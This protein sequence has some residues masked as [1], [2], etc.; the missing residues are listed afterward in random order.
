MAVAIKYFQPI[1]GEKVGFGR[2][3]IKQAIADAILR[4]EHTFYGPAMKRARDLTDS[5]VEALAGTE[6]EIVTRED[7]QNAVKQ[8]MW[9]IGAY[10]LAEEYLLYGAGVELVE[11]GLIRADQFT[12]DGVPREEVSKIYGWNEKHDCHT[13]KGLN[14]WFRGEGGRDV[15][16]LIRAAEEQ[17]R[18]ELEAAAQEFLGKQG[19]RML[20]VCGPSSSGKTTTANRVCGTISELTHGNLTFRPLEVD[21]FFQPKTA[22][23]KYTYTV[24]GK[25]V[26]D[27]DYETPFAYDLAALNEV[28]ERI[29]R[30]ETVWMPKYDFGTGTNIPNATE[31]PALG[32]NEVLVF[33]CLHALY[34]DITAAVP[35]EQKFKLY[36]EAMNTIHGG[37]RYLRWTDVR[38]IRRMLRDVATRGHDTLLTLVHWHLVRKGEGA[39][40]PLINTA[41]VRINGGLAYELPVFKAHAERFFRKYLEILKRNPQLGDALLRAERVCELFDKLETATEEQM[42]HIPSDSILREFIGGSKF[43]PRFPYGKLSEYGA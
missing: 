32:P 40:F 3:P 19:M 17:K 31:F 36:I 41:D 30:G 8:A 35:N 23:Q 15:R 14:G 22:N 28:L 6:Q 33:D 9:K 27:W 20:I 4:T 24:D 10:D 5:A 2:A 13:I 12:P 38:L 11:R 29:M 25:P 37:D 18:V 1:K 7:V 34:P 43:F 16:E 21:M 42:A 39:M 26:Y